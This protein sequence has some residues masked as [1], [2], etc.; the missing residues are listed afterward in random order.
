MGSKGNSAKIGRNGRAPSNKSYAN[1]APVNK[2][3][4]IARHKKA[5]ER[6]RSKWLKP[7][8]PA[9]V[10][11]GFAR[12]LRRERQRATANTQAAA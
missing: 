9:R 12:S 8:R 7:R 5:M 10:Q 11:R 3:R 4:R 2:A 1:R 6:A